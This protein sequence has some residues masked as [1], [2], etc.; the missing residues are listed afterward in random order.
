MQKEKNWKNMKCS[1]KWFEWN[2]YIYV[3]KYGS[4]RSVN[5]EPYLNDGIL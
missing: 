2:I 3:G 1:L 4:M 5:K